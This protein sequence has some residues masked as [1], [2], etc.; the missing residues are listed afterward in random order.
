VGHRGRRG[1]TLVE[2]LVVVLILSVL[3]C[4][5]LP[6]YLSAVADAQKKVCRTN[7]QTI[8][9]AVQAARIKTSAE[10]FSTWIGSSY[11]TWPGTTGKLPDLSAVPACPNGGT[12]AIAQGNSSDNTTFKVD[13]SYESGAIVHGSYQPGIDSD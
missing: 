6:T 13:C 10:D 7:L 4:V 5:G 3:L 11:T 8:A 12:Y 2:L 1:F 9:N